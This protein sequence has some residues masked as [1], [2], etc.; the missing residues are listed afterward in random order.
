LAQ[1]VEQMV[2][3]Y[4]FLKL[5]IPVD[6]IKRE[7]ESQ[8]FYKQKENNGSGVKS[9]V[10]EASKGPD[11]FIGKKEPDGFIRKGKADSWKKELNIFQKLTI[12]RYTRKLMRECG[13]DWNGR[14]K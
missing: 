8:L 9:L 5:D 7:V 14:V 6:K 4:D 12:W 11:G 13:Y 2:R 3:I 1:P 10:A